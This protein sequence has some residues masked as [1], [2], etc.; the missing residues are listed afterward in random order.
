MQNN[1]IEDLNKAESTPKEESYGGFQYRHNYDEYKK[2]LMEKQKRTRKSIVLSVLLIIGLVVL[3]LC[4]GAY[5]ADTILKTKGSSLSAIFQSSSAVS[6]IPHK[7]ELT[8]SKINELSEKYTVTVTA[9][10]ENGA[11]IILTED[12][13]IATS[14]SLIKDHADF[15][16]KINGKEHKASLIGSDNEGDT[17]VIKVELTGLTAAEI[18]Y[19]RALE[20]GQEVYC[21]QGDKGELGSLVVY[22]ATDALKIITEPKCFVPGAPLINSYGQVVG[23]V[24]DKSGTSCHLDAIL[25]FIK[26][27]LSDNASITV[28]RSPVFISALGIYV[29]S[30]SEKQSEIYKIPLGCFVTSA[31]SSDVFVKGDIIVSVEDEEITTS[32]ELTRLVKSGSVVK[33]YRNNSYIELTV[34]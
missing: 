12:G 27:M 16:V 20:R 29:E 3:I 8:E 31:H 32:E 33:V 13:Y 24:S 7:S 23:M 17:A 30:V 9:G 26:K 1:N 6:T 34:K 5:I 22:D 28:S 2:E 21:K 25:P 4:L 15:F 19:S 14:Y 18:G 10:A 11:G